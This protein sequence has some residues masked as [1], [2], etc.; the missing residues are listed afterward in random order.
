MRCVEADS[1]AN[2]MLALWTTGLNHLSYT[3]QATDKV[4]LSSPIATIDHDS[5]RR[6]N[7]RGNHLDLNLVGSGLRDVKLFIDWGF[8]ELSDDK[9]VLL[10]GLHLG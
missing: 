1:F 2:K 8:L 6:V 5:I 7:C 9:S 4:G 3:L 10:F